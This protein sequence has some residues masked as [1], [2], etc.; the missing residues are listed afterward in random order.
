MA[1]VLEEGE[2]PNQCYNMPLLEHDYCEDYL[3]SD[4]ENIIFVYITDGG[5]RGTCYN[6]QMLRNADMFYRC[7]PTDLNSY[8]SE[9]SCIKI[10]MGDFQIYI[11]TDTAEEIMMSSCRYFTIE[12]TP[13][14]YEFTVSANALESGDG[15]STDHC[16]ANSDKKIHSVTCRKRESIDELIDIARRL[17]FGSDSD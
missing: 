7:D 11:T 10:S 8:I 15:N 9:D 16:Q 5:V 17:S 1:I 2:L 6:F 4:R 12:S 13:I 3:D 14:E